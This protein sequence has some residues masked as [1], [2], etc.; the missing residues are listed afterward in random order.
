MKVH[1]I[2]SRAMARGFAW[3]HSGGGSL[4]PD[5]APQ[6]FLQFVSGSPKGF[7]TFLLATSVG[8]GV[9]DA[10][11]NATRSG[12]ESGTGLPGG[13]AHCDHVIELLSH[14]LVHGF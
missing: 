1:E 11:M 8:S 10:P 4:F 3:W 12:Q 2:T 6:S 7:Q 13:I 5:E 9:F 14:K